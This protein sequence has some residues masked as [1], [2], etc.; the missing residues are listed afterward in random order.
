MR[1]VCR[2]SVVA[3]AL[4]AACGAVTTVA[5]AADS[6]TIDTPTTSAASAVTPLRITNGGLFAV[7]GTFAA[8][9]GGSDN[10]LVIMTVTGST[11]PVST[12]NPNVPS[13]L[14][15]RWN[16]QLQAPTVNG[17]QG[18]R[19]DYTIQA[20]CRAGT[21]VKNVDTIKVFIDVP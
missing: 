18:T 4:L 17:P 2:F 15:N 13:G 14:N 12:A 11:T 10:I 6:V 1:R 20:I 9:G 3:S 19:V 8:G 21:T 7:A 5:H 16:C